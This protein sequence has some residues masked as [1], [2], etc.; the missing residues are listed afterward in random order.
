MREQINIMIMVDSIKALVD[1]SL[2]G[3]CFMVDDSCFFS[4]QKG[5]L[6][7]D[8]QCIP[9][10]KI[11]W[12]VKAVDVQTPVSIKQI[13]FEP[14]QV[15]F[16]TTHVDNLD[17][18]VWNGIVPYVGSKQMTYKYKIVLQIGK[19]KKSRLATFTPSLTILP[20]Y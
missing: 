10:Q 5:T 1:Q 18:L 8:T 15:Y 13:S 11:H 17:A 6:Y 16:N 3:N 9:D 14:Y 20:P 19:G 12:T 4:K 2:E 7:L